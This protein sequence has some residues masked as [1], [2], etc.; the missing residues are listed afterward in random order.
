MA[1]PRPFNPKALKRYALP[2]IQPQLGPET[3]VRRYTVLVPMEQ[4]LAEK[5]PRKIASA[6]D[7][8]RIQLVLI[9]DFGGVTMA[10]TI[11]S[12][13]GWGARDPRKPKK[14]RELNRHAYFTVYAAGRPRLR[15]ILPCFAKRIG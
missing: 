13:L 11:P 14:S 10:T 9:R 3:L 6:E 15:R 7:L 5:P 12:L 2:A 1:A 4:I 8:E